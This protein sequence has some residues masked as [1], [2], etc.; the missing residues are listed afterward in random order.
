MLHGLTHSRTHTST[1]TRHFEGYKCYSI[2]N[3]PH[4]KGPPTS[5]HIILSVSDK[6]MTHLQSVF[7]KKRERERIRC[8]CHTFSP[9]DFSSASR[10]TKLGYVPKTC[11]SLVARG[12]VKPKLSVKEQR[13][14]SVHWHTIHAAKR[15]KNQKAR[16]PKERIEKEECG[17]CVKVGG[18]VGSPRAIY[19]AQ[20]G[21]TE[22][23]GKRRSSKKRTRGGRRRAS[24][25]IPL[26]AA[27]SERLPV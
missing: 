23:R 27:A 25:D 17:F 1:L 16:T 20:L 13:C 11:L 12:A 8:L 4:R 10:E 22:D 26:A 19:R 21:P 14:T 2:E 18:T 24:D 7:I 5:A 6:Q 15:S 3:K 9:S